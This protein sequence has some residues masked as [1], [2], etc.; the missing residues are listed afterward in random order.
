MGSKVKVQIQY[1]VPKNDCIKCEF[2]EEAI[3][4]YHGKVHLCF[5]FNEILSYSTSEKGNQRI[6]KVNRC[7][8]CKRAEVI[9]CES[10][11]QTENDK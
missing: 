5:L 7:A 11:E 3:S 9:E 2:Y 6:F 8:M 1:E 4:D 10:T